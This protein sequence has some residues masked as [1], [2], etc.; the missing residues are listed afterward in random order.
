[1]CNAVEYCSVD[2]RLPLR[3]RSGAARR[4]Q[5]SCG[6]R[7]DDVTGRDL[8]GRQAGL[9]PGKVYEADGAAGAGCL[10]DYIIDCM[11]GWIKLDTIAEP[12]CFP[13]HQ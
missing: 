10:V 6:P 11:G 7:R 5:T 13:N 3:C 1:M 8:T 9:G 4:R 2:S 12:F